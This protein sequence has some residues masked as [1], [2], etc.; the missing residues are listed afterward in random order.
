MTTECHERCMDLALEEA[1]KAEGSG[2]VPVGAVIIDTSGEIVG[3]GYN[4]PISSSDPTAHAEIIALREA[5]AKT[6]NY[7]LA[8]ATLYCT[9]EPCVM[10][11]GAIIH[12]RIRRVVFGAPD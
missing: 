1:R 10:C 6:A 12:A 11:A 8:G 9:I 3:R 2:E 5:A 7:R 4:R